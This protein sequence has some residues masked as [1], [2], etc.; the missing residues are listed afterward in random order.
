M[1]RLMK[2]LSLVFVVTITSTI[3]THADVWVDEDEQTFVIIEDGLFSIYDTGSFYFFDE[4]FS[5]ARKGTALWLCIGNDE[6]TGMA[7]DCILKKVPVA[8]FNNGGK[9]RSLH[10]EIKE[11]P[12]IFK[13]LEQDLRSGKSVKVS[14]DNGDLF[15]AYSLNANFRLNQASLKIL[16]LPD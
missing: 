9:T 6:E 11:F 12:Y 2:M 3:A 8:G 5:V 15:A 1:D 14:I 16:E 13:L 10:F 7:T 4:L